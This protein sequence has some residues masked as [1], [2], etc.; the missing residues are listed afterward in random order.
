MIMFFYDPARQNDRHGECLKPGSDYGSFKSKTD[1]EI[2]LHH[3]RGQT[4]QIFFPLISKLLTLQ[5]LKI[6][7]FYRPSYLLCTRVIKQA[8][9]T[10]VQR[11]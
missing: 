6:L 4:S 2:R 11:A 3:T 8:T 10:F 1:F 5:E 9:L 7:Y